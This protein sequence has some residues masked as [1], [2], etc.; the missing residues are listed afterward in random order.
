MNKSSAKRIAIYPGSFDPVTFGH[1]DIIKTAAIIFDELYVA[2]ATNTGKTPLF[3]NEERLELM[4]LATQDIPNVKVESFEGLI[5]NYA[6][7]K[8]ACSMIRSI[9]AVS[10]FDYEFQ[11]ALANQKLD[12]EIHTMFV[13]PSEAHFYISSRL[14][15]EIVLFGGDVTRFV[16]PFVANK[17][18]NKLTIK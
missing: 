14:I 17:L 5:V 13:M 16:P 2:V 9:R 6:R 10:D 11:M 3:E 7:K 1:I 18:K 15:K 4:K 12:P 8:S